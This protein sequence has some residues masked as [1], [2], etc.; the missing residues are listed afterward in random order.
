MA[1]RRWLCRLVLI[2]VAGLAST[3]GAAPRPGQ[4]SLVVRVASTDGTLI[5]VECAGAGPSLVL[6]HGG[7]GDRTRWTP[8]FPLFS[9]R[10]TVDIAR[11]AP[12]T[13]RTLTSEGTDPHGGTRRNGHLDFHVLWPII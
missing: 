13:R 7:T 11:R 1:R 2:L 12:L 10:F 3:A 9:S 5:A 4:S 8:L 6:V